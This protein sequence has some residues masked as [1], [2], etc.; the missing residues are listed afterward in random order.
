MAN[1]TVR[2]L[3]L[4]ADF[5]DPIVVLRQAET[6]GADGIA[7]VTPQRFDTVASVQASSGDDLITLPD[8]SRAS[9]IYECITDFPLL[10]PSDA[11]TN[12]DIVIWRNMRFRV[13]S[14]AVFANFGN[15]AG[16]Y[17]AMMEMLPVR[18]NAG[19][20][21]SGTEWDDGQTIWDDGKTAWDVP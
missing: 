1:I 7:V 19:A 18:V 12:A 20:T 14:V 16:H 21:E 9:S 13:T 3:L 11:V 15:G 10:A 4:D 8:A 6:V 17:E 2:E 5:V